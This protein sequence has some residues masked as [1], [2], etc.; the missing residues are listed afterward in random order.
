[1]YS[2]NQSFAILAV[3][4]LLVGLAC[5]DGKS[6]VVPSQDES[7]T[8]QS[9]YSLQSHNRYLWGYY[10]VTMN[11]ETGEI[12][13]RPVRN[14]QAHYNIMTFLENGPCHNCLRITNTELLG[15]VPGWAFD[16][17]I[18]HPFAQPRFRGFDV[19]CIVMFRATWHWEYSEIY[20]SNL[21]ADNPELINAD[22]HTRLYQPS[23]EDSGPM[24]LQGYQFG[25][26]ATPV[27]PSSTLNGFIN[28]E[29]NFSNNDRNVFNAGDT[30]N[31]RLECQFPE[32]FPSVFH[33]GY[34]VDACWAPP[35]GTGDDISD[36]PPEANCPEPWSLSIVEDRIG[37][38]LYEH[39]GTTLLKIRVYE[40]EPTMTHLAPVVEAPDFEPGLVTAEFDGYEGTTPV[41]YAQIRNEKMADEGIYR[42]LVSVE[43]ELNDTAPDYLDLTSYRMA[44][45]EVRGYVEDHGWA[46]TWGYTGEDIGKAVTSD[47]YGNVYAGGTFE[48]AVDFN[49]DPDSLW[50]RTSNGLSDCFLSK[51]SD[52]GRLEWVVTWGGENADYLNDIEVS[53]EGEIYAV[54]RFGASVDFDPSEEGEYIETAGGVADA[55]VSRFDFTGGWHWTTTWGGESDDSANGV[56]IHRDRLLVCGRFQGSTD[57]GHGGPV[58]VSNGEDDAFVVRFDP[59]T[60]T[61]LWAKTWGGDNA[62]AAMDLD[63]EYSAVDEDRLLYVCGYFNNNS[64]GAGVDFDPGPGEEIIESAG[65]ID[66]YVTKFD[67]ANGEHLLTYTWGSEG[68]DN[69]K[70]VVLNQINA[71]SIGGYISGSVD[72]DPTEGEQMCYHHGNYD[73]FIVCFSPED[74]FVFGYGWGG[75]G[76]DWVNDVDDDLWGNPFAVGGYSGEVNFDPTGGT[77]TFASNGGMDCFISYFQIDSQYLWTFTWGGGGEDQAFG[78]CGGD[79]IDSFTTGK[80]EGTV[81]FSAGEHPDEHTSEGMQD[82]FLLKLLGDGGW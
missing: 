30:V 14:I 67:G 59:V 50:V 70:G 55:F 79:W 18:T 48:D 19:R 35:D 74:D 8:S 47:A 65:G 20:M 4:L 15:T 66:A 42:V 51:Y 61:D 23:T 62:D 60:G 16:V 27:K 7:I 25:R 40:H 11:T 58:S 64:G 1:M 78:V 57:F 53:E 80:F 71:W 10:D 69:A 75:S 21:A 22:G 36:F 77:N 32:E 72:L 44:D 38:G 12:S 28:Y 13:A 52:T 39:G 43:D 17:A 34:A 33:F 49:P 82:A 63:H 46:K 2:Q 54:G 73:A 56:S 9:D 81:D 3:T 26:L 41:W 29:S 45:V 6:P 68:P 76:Y 5:S 31:R 37:R 24:G